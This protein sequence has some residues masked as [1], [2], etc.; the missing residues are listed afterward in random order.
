M[1]S[2]NWETTAA[3]EERRSRAWESLGRRGLDDPR[4]CQQEARYHRWWARAARR[5]AELAREDRRRR[6]W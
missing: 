5:N 6:R 1:T 3:E 2:R 4:R